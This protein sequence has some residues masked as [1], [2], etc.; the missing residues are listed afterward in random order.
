MVKICRNRACI[1]TYILG[2][3][4]PLQ[5]RL[6]STDTLQAVALCGQLVECLLILGG[7]QAVTRLPERCFA[8]LKDG[9][10]EDLPIDT[11]PV[12]PYGA[13]A[14][15][16]RQIKFALVCVRWNTVYCPPGC[17]LTLTPNR[18]VMVSLT[19]LERLHLNLGGLVGIIDTQHV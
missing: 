19:F 14:L 1:E 7:V 13:I 3:D 16:D 8:L 2:A 17:P 10:I 6:I 11:I 12:Y 5:I 9:G 18:G 4:N 15:A